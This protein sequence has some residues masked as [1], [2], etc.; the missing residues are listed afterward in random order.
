VVATGFDGHGKNQKSES[1]KS[2]TPNS[3]IVEKESESEIRP[4]PINTSVDKNKGKFSV[5]K[6]LPVKPALE[7]KAEKPV[8]QEDDDLSVP[9]FIRKKMN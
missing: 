2:Y 7:K 5:F 9:A 4:N 1:S 6:N 3:F 8:D